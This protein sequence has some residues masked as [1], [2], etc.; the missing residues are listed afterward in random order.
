MSYWI[1][2]I[3]APLSILTIGVHGVPVSFLSFMSLGLVAAVNRLRYSDKAVLRVI[4]ALAA[5][6]YAAL[7]LFYLYLSAQ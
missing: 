4:A 1:A 6:L 7:L 2:I 3:V 5:S